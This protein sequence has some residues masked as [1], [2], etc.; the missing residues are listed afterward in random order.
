MR[1]ALRLSYDGT[2]FAGWWRQSDARSVA[3]E[4]DAACARIGEPTAAAVGTS[5]TDAGVHA[6]GQVAHV[7]LTRTRT[8][9]QLHAALN[10]HL[11]DD[12]VCRAVAPVAGDWHAVHDAR[13]KT[14]GY[15]IDNAAVA[16]PFTRRQ[17]WRPQY[18]L[19]L[20]AL[21]DAATGIVGCRDWCG[22]ARRGDARE[23][24]V[25]TITA[26]DWSAHDDELRCSVSG[27]GFVYRLVRSLV[28]AMVAVAH[29]G[30]ARAE[31]D[32]ALA[33]ADSP[34]GR[35]QAPAHGLCLE[36]VHYDPQPAWWPE[37]AGAFTPND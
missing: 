32:A 24:L 4:L 12:V 2:D 26:V 33:G 20:D 1:Y 17:C 34:A 27:D 19:T 7:D 36:A 18:R 16:E 13:S 22:F 23:D 35:Q 37:N 11:P 25:R 10:T 9:T 21:R 29:G 30:C 15:R 8:P 5:R 14:Y 3:A 31:L 28:G 6:R